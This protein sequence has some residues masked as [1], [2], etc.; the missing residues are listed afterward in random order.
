[1]LLDKIQIKSDNTI[2]K[3]RKIN[4]KYTAILRKMF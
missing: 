4:L 1:M 2:Q 3:E